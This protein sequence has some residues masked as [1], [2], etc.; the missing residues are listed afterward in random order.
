[1]DPAGEFPV[2]HAV[3]NS[4]QGNSS[5]SSKQKVGMNTQREGSR[6]MKLIARPQFFITWMLINP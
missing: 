3:R 6:G 5:S 2:F 1:M 4:T